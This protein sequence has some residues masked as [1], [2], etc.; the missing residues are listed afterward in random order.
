RRADFHFLLLQAGRQT[1]T[2]DIGEPVAATQVNAVT[3]AV[4]RRGRV[5]RLEVAVLTAATDE[6]TPA[7]G[8]LPVAPVG[9]Q[10]G[11]QQVLGRAQAAVGHFRQQADF[12]GCREDR[13]RLVTEDLL[14]GY[15]RVNHI[16]V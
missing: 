7:A 14:H 13:E 3:I 1:Q 12:P 5:R 4:T 2:P 11:A 15:G 6:T 8:L 9:L 10:L 16:C